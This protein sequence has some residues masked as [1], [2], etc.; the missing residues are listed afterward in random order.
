[1][2]GKDDVSPPSKVFA[3]KMKG[4]LPPIYIIKDVILAQ[5][6]FFLENTIFLLILESIP[7]KN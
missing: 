5:L 6:S 3:Q 2:I 7:K 1:M 4:D